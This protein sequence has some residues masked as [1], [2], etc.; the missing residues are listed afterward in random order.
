MP[1]SIK[2]CMVNQHKSPGGNCNIIV[3]SGLNISCNKQVTIC[4]FPQYKNQVCKVFYNKQYIRH[5]F[6]SMN[7]LELDIQ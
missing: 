6:G 5:K 2:Q 4:N 1:F 7:Q 3:G